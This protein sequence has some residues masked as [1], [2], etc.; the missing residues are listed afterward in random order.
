MKVH[1]YINVSLFIFV[2][3]LSEQNV[4]NHRFNSNEEIKITS[5]VQELN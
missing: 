4:F 3:I 2:L 5:T 1:L